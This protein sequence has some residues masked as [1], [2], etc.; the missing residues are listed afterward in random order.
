MATM[1]LPFRFGRELEL[2]SM[3]E[4]GD[5][6]LVA[7]SGGVD[8]CVM[9]HLFNLL[10]NKFEIKLTVSHINHKLRGK[11]S[12]LDEEFVRNM[13]LKYGLKFKCRRI[14]SK[15]LKG[16]VQS[17]ARD[18]RYKMLSDIAKEVGANKIAFAHNKNDQAE[19]VLLNLV[20]GSG[21]D[22]LSG[23]PSTRALESGISIVRPMMLFT[24]A[25]IL[26]FAKDKKIR[27]REDA[28]NAT[29]KYSR[30][31]LRHLV[32][33]ELLKLNPR[34]IDHIY[35]T[36]VRVSDD[37]GTLE[38]LSKNIFK[39]VKIDEKSGSFIKFK[40]LSY[41]DQPKALRLRL[42]RHA[43]SSITGST[44]DLKADHIMR[45]DQISISGEG[46]AEYRL[47]RGVRFCRR[48]NILSMSKEQKR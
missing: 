25:E 4:A 38:D 29:T 48:K 2:S 10:K 46:R 30:N 20:R 7:V 36:S 1:D 11:D 26:R 13:A 40:R 43:Y 45:I 32:I 47:P 33:P 24:R 41:K 23:M 22:G 34:V 18:N 8:S 27:Y 39:S 6:V 14:K 12:D 16:N 9:L 37:D 44:K 35:D 28:T 17:A 3:I 15:S 19:T 5:H 42:I 21:L 31:R